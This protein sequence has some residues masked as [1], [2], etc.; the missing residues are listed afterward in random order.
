MKLKCTRD[1]FESVLTDSESVLPVS[2][3]AQTSDAARDSVKLD[4][5]L[6]TLQV[7]DVLPGHLGLKSGVL[8]NGL[9]YCIFPNK[10]PAGRFYVNLEVNAGSTDEEE[11]QRGL[12]HFLEHA[13]FLGTEKF[14]TQKAMK[15]LLRRLGMA[16]NADANAFTDFRST[17]YTLSAP[18]RG[19]A[20]TVESNAGLFGSG[21]MTTA[22]TEAVM[23]EEEDTGQLDAGGDEDG[24][25][26]E[27]VLDLLY[28]MVFK[29]RLRQEDIDRERGA[30][31][32][33]LKD[34]DSIS[35]RIAM[36]YYRFHHWCLS[37]SLSLSLCVCVYAYI[38]TYIHVCVC[39]HICIYMY[40]Y[41][42]MYIHTKGTD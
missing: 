27:L 29:A 1:H 13:V 37:L 32:S 16:Y 5:K 6:E 40:T 8:P 14:P 15:Q 25:N 34:R 11:H 4:E 10:K 39:T 41:I 42:R 9:R 22:P 28:E 12:A 38:H 24:D 3:S 30:V 21:G 23:E 26:T 19:R 20:T 18:V 17:V 31:L 7:S 2:S 35:Q 36:E 33:E